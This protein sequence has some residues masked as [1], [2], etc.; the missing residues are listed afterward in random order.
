MEWSKEKIQKKA[1][2][3]TSMCLFVEEIDKKGIC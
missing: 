1:V 2:G 3:S